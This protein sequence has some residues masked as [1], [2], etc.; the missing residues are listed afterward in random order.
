MTL[1]I[2]IASLSV[3]R[4]ATADELVAFA[5]RALYAA[6][7]SGKDRIVVFNRSQRLEAPAQ[8]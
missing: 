5:D 3:H 7:N 6:K 8:A 1:S 2:G 4:P